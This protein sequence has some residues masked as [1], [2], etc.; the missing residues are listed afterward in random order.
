MYK[1]M[2]ILRQLVRAPKQIPDRLY[3]ISMESLS[4]R[5]RHP[6]CGMSSWH[7]KTRRDGCNCSQGLTLH[8]GQSTVH[9][10]S[11]MVLSD[12]LYILILR[13]STSRRQVQFP[14]SLTP[15]FL[16]TSGL[17]VSNGLSGPRFLILSRKSPSL[18]QEILF[19]PVRRCLLVRLHGSVVFSPCLN[20]LILGIVTDGIS[21]P[22]KKKTDKQTKREDCKAIISV[23]YTLLFIF[24]VALRPGKRSPFHVLYS[25]LVVTQTSY[26]NKNKSSSY[27]E[28]KLLRARSKKPKIRKWD[29]EAMQVHVSCKFISGATKVITIF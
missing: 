12:T 19:N 25:R 17:R 3:V 15:T 14:P 26:G 1:L 11:T 18:Y 21:S 29:W 10:L 23:H 22:K 6:S 5:S 20:T 24:P 13:S 28:Y 8:Q 4:L 2:Q 27:Q 9:L 7:G 16:R